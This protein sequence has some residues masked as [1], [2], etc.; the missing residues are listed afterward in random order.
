MEDHIYHCIYPLFFQTA[1]TDNQD[2]DLHDVNLS[3]FTRIYMFIQ[4]RR[5]IVANIIS[6]CKRKNPSLNTPLKNLLSVHEMLREFGEAD[7][8]SLKFELMEE[9]KYQ[10]K[11]DLV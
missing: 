10:L 1:T 7:I 4:K 3:Y 2:A 6:E 5:L 8:D 9:S 11:D